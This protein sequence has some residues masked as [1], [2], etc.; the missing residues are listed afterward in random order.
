[1]VELSKENIE[2]IV[3]RIKDYM[4]KEF[5]LEIGGFEAEFLLDFFNKELG[6]K[7]YNKALLEISDEYKIKFDNISED[8]IYNLEKQ[9]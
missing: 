1:M 8:I 6:N 5:D 3:P 4:F 9:N 7:I 2:D